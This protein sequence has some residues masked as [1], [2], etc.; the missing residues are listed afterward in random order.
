M[1]NTSDIAN[2]KTN[3]SASN[4]LC[5]RLHELNASV[6]ISSYQS[7]LIYLV[8]RNRQGGINIHQ[9]T[10][11]RPMGMSAAVGDNISFNNK[12]LTLSTGCGVVQFQNTLE[13]GQEINEAF[14]TCYVPRVIYMTG[15]LD[16]HVVGVSSENTA[17]FVNTRFNCLATPSAKYSFEMIW[18]PP[19]IS[20]LI[21]EDR[22]HLNG[23]AI[24]GGKP[25]YVTAISQSDTIDGWR[26]R[27][28]NGGV[29]ID[30]ESDE[31]VCTGLSMP[32]SPRWHNGQLW[33]LNS[34]TG[35][36]GT[37]PLEGPDKGKFRPISFCP[38]FLRGLSFHGNLA[39]VGLSR[40]RY[41][42]FEGLALDARL[43]EADSDP[44]CG[45]QFIDLTTGACVDWLRFDGATDELYDVKFLTDVTCPMAVAPTSGDIAGLITFDGMKAAAPK[46]EAVTP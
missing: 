10:I 42:R 32:H 9:T 34:G 7:N 5:K 18:K 46:R 19:F 36:L 11:Q 13:Q 41:K 23:I 45:I 40:P 27:R 12:R 4:G 6:A 39:I 16:A 31:I 44:W 8:G 21:D 24:R 22:C 15:N 3:F 30:V 35:E 37:V 28:A 25:K 17:I 26:D 29:I 1:A 38:G 20:E 14:D 2:E 43:K 33:V